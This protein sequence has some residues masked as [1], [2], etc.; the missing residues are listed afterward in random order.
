MICI[1]FVNFFWDFWM[2]I[3]KVLDLIDECSEWLMTL[4]RCLLKL[5]CWS[6]STPRNFFSCCGMILWFPRVIVAA[7]FLL[8]LFLKKMYMV[9]EAFR[10]IFQCSHR[11][12]IFVNSCCNF[13]SSVLQLFLVYIAMSSAN[14]DKWQFGSVGI[15]YIENNN[16][17]DS[18]LEARPTMVKTVEIW[19]H[20][21][22]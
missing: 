4:W 18:F 13:F 5:R 22:L 11:V 6:N 21:C 16:R 2:C 8:F 14:C 15:T 12:L 19:I 7:F 10:Q 20:W 17:L 9:F 3:F 1:E